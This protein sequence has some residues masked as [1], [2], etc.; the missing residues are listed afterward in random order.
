[1]TFKQK[2]G[3]AM[4]SIKISSEVDSKMNHLLAAFKN[5]IPHSHSIF[6]FR[7]S[8]PH[9]FQSP[10]ETPIETKKLASYIDHTLLRADATENEIKTLCEE[11][12]Q[13]HFAT[14]C[15]QSSFIPFASQL[16]KNQT[17]L[18]ISVV[19]FPLGAMDSNSKAFEAKTAVNQGAKEIDMVLHLGHLKS[20]NYSLV[21]QDIEEV[22]KTVSPI[23]VKVILETCYL[24]EEEKIAACLLSKAAGAAFVKTST[25][26]GTPKATQENP[27]P[28]NGATL[29]DILLMRYI[30]GPEMGVKASGG[31]RTRNDAENLIKAG[32]S[33]LGTSAGVT[34]LASLNSNQTHLSSGSY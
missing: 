10:T 33:R 5:F 26:F 6:E 21:Y 4:H 3:N 13:Y 2:I 28:T 7:Q 12:I 8:E 24:N 16:L 23:P 34:L 25:G 19:G 18:P 15:V 31:I 14:V 32:A 20:K 17:S 9:S 29:E 27:H 22:V 30:V 11:A 1:M